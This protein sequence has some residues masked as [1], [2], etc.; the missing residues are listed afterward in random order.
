MGRGEE[1]EGETGGERERLRV[2]AG[3]DVLCLAWL[4]EV[5]WKVEPVG[6]YLVERLSELEEDDDVV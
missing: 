4:V 2:V 5:N 6:R 1:K 3:Y